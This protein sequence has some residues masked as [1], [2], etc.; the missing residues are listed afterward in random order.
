MRFCM[1]RSLLYSMVATRRQKLIVFLSC[2]I[3]AG[4]LIRPPWR[5]WYVA[6]TEKTFIFRNHDWI[7]SPPGH[8]MSNGAVS[9]D[10]PRLALEV[11]AVAIVALGALFA[12][13][14]RA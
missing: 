14:A 7:F 4:F 13:R 12:L 3:A 1:S 2:L 6:G 5:E 9:L 11:L 10:L 8:V